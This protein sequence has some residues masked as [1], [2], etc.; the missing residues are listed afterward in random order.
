M[1]APHKTALAT[2]GAAGVRVRSARRGD[3]EGIAA[4]LRELGYPGAAD[5]STVNWVVSHP[6]SEIFVAADGHD[7]PV[8]LLSLSHRP[9]LRMNGRIATV[10]E[11]V[12]AAAWRRRGV[13]RALLAR[14]VEKA[15]TLSC[16]RLELVTHRGRG[17]YVRQFYLAC[18]FDEADSTV[19]RLRDL[20]F[21]RR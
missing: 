17:D 13:G 16:K 4:L 5:I 18:G 12:V 2:E 6:E 19:L 14:A 11:M 3:A 10:D 1:A 21:Q 15:K 9:Q 20:D 7:R 8:G